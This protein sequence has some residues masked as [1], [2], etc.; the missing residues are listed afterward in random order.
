MTNEIEFKLT[1]ASAD[2]AK[3]ATQPLLHSATIKQHLRL[4]SVYYDTPK[5]AL[6]QQRAALRVRQ[7]GNRWI[8][9]IKIGGGAINGL[10]SR[11]EW[12]VELTNQ[13]PQPELFTD[14]LVTQLLTP[15]LTQQLTPIFQTD[16]WRNTWLINFHGA[17][18]EI[19]LDQGKV[20]SLAQETPICEVEL[21]LK[22]GE[23]QQLIELAQL[24]GQHTPLT[25]DSISKAQRGYKLYQNQIV[26]AS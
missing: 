14:P 8:Q 9:T 12:E 23:A 15:E 10:H 13:Q 7:A 22:Q 26:I 18:I 21:E 11:P 17:Q 3:F 16:F 25:P 24:L 20:I 1:I 6:M 2:T 19:A 5:L 4:I